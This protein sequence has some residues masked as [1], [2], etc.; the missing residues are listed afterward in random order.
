[1]TT[2]TTTKALAYKAGGEAPWRSETPSE[3]RDGV[4][5][6]LDA[7]GLPVAACYGPKVEHSREVCRRIVKAVN[8]HDELVACL[9][10]AMKAGNLSYSARIAD[11][12]AA[13]CDAVDRAHAAIAKAEG[14]A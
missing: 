6:V 5:Y 12:N 14:A 2:R 4:V 9:K 3:H 11:Q 8:L 1:M 13:H 7:E 10:W